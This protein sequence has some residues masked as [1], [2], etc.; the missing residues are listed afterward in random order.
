VLHRIP[1][2]PTGG[3]RAG[4]PREPNRFQGALVLDVVYLAATIALFALVALLARGVEKL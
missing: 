4:P 1:C 2:P 3:T